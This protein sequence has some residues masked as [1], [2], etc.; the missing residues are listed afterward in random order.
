[1]TW[2][3]GNCVGADIDRSTDA[4]ELRR[5]AEERLAA[6]LEQVDVVDDSARWPGHEVG[7]P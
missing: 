3:S 6:E 2:N 7:E 5:R 4:E 1:M